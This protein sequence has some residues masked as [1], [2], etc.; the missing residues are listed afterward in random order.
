[1]DLPA[2]P[3]AH[4]LPKGVA[5]DAIFGSGFEPPPP[6]GASV[7]VRV[8]TKLAYGPRPG[9]VAAFNALGAS[10]AAR[11]AAYVEQQLA[12]GA[13][14]DSACENRIA[15]GAYTTLGKSLSQLWSDHVRD[16]D[17]LGLDE[18]PDRYF[19][20]AETQCAR[21]LRAVYSERQL[22]ERMVEFWH[23]HFNVSGWAFDIAPQFVHYDRDVIRPRA[24]GNFR[25]MLEEIAK[26]PAM[27]F[28]L[29]NKSSTDAGFN[30][31]YARE[32]C[33]LHTL[34]AG[35]YY[36][37]NDP[38]N[39]PLGPDNK[40]R[41]YCDNDVYEV[42]RALT[43][44]TLR[45]AHWQFP[46]L[47]EYDTG[48]FLY[49]DDW[50]DKA[51][52]FILGTYIVANNPAGALADGRRAMDLL[53][54]HPGT[55]RHICT[56]LIR[57]FITDE[58]PDYRDPPY[59]PL[60]ESAAAIWVANWQAPDQIAQVLRHILNSPLLLERWGEKTKRPFEIFAQAMRATGAQ[61]TPQP[62]GDWNPYGQLDALMSQTGHGCYRWPTPDGYPDVGRVWQAV[63]VLAQTW[64]LNSRLPEL[65][66]PGN[67]NTA[68]LM[69]VHEITLAQLPAGSRTAA[70][71]VDFWLARIVGFEIAPARRTA[72]V[73]FM[74][75]N[76]AADAVLNLVEDDSDAGVPRHEGIWSSGNLSRHKS[77]ARLRAMVS[78]IFCLPEF[79]LR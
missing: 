29:D 6:E 43:G 52:K 27:L 66:A 42:A 20:A 2:A 9:D 8:L 70:V 19:P 39:V 31:N 3:T 41:G 18:W 55:A 33:E 68:F 49:W 21:M 36:P 73:D 32:L 15:A 51:G 56:K 16:R 46:A 40:P 25:Q 47:P 34:G 24:L 11:L 7:A 12:P 59:H 69:R 61:F 54:Q 79:Y 30:E 63:G 13:I 67:G 64:R 57:R 72:L 28:F 58:L 62:F 10:D 26:A 1:M 4:A 23:D 35:N 5:P 76:A 22:F 37:G 44:W 71:I 38:A 78:L 48:E 17:N 74:R 53:C 60:V 45:D 14:D 75:Q 65:R 50:H 77:I